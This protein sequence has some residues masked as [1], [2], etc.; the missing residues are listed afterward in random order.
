MTYDLQQDY[1]DR[2]YGKDE[3]AELDSP[4]T[5]E[6]IRQALASRGTRWSWW[7]G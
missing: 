5:V 7:G 3:V 4:V 1:L 2:G 6:A